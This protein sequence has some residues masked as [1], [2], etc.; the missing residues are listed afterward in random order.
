MKMCKLA[1][2]MILAAVTMLTS[3]LGDSDNSTTLSAIPGVYRYHNMTFMIET[4]YGYIYSSDLISNPKYTYL[5]EG[6]CVAVSFTYGSAVSGDSDT[7]KDYTTVQ[8]NELVTLDSGNVSFS[9]DTA[10]LKDKEFSMLEGAIFSSA[11]PTFAYL[12]SGVMFLTSGYN[13][14]TKQESEFYLYFD[15][16]Q[17]PVADNAG[18]VYSIFLRAVATTEGK[19][20][21]TSVAQTVGYNV[22]NMIN[23]INEREKA[24]SNSAFQLKINF[25]SDIEDSTI[26]VWKAVE[27]KIPFEV[28]D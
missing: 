24:K 17:E 7:G 1:L 12:Q 10:T 11:Y 14:L 8:L 18:N 16:S 21:S 5:S 4:P 27:T 26:P 9:T 6:D 2:A 3:C 13:M 25:V 15:P 23:I 19:A 22:K 20:P 28:T